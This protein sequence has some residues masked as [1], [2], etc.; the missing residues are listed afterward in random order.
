MY[1]TH[2]MQ[3]GQVVFQDPSVCHAHCTDLCVLNCSSKCIS[4]LGHNYNV[5]KSLLYY[6]EGLRQKLEAAT[7]TQKAMGW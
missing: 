3:E 2:H 7:F 4:Y 5:Q 1:Q 6:M